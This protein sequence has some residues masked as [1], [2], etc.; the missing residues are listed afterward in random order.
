LIR[1]GPYKYARHPIYTGLLGVFF[2]SAVA[3]GELRGL[4]AVALA[5]AAFLVKS[6]R[7]E[8]LMVGHFGAEY[9]A[10]RR[11]VKALIP[12]VY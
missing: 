4:L 7:E 6:R 2:G 1:G 9:E 5:F 12:Y 3:L 10:Y 8:K 11:E